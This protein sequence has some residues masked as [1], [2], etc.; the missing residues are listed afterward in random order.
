MVVSLIDMRK[1]NLRKWALTM[2]IVVA[3]AAIPLTVFASAPSLNAKAYIVVDADTG[4]ILFE[5]NSDDVLVPASMT[6]L[7]TL[8]LTLEK[9]NNNKIK[10]SDEAKISEYSNKISRVSS[11]S[12]YQLPTGSIYSIE[13]LYFGAAINSSN[14]SAIALSEYIAGDETGFIALMNDKARNFGLTDT[15][16]VN[17]S[18]LNNS[19]LYGFHPR[20]TGKNEDTKISARSMATVAYRLVNDYPEIINTS[21]LVQKTLK[22]GQPGEITIRSTNRLLPSRDYAFEGAKGL[23]TGYIYNAGYC[24]AGYAERPSGRVISVVMGAVSS[25]ERFRGSAKLM[26][27]GFELLSEKANAKVEAAYG[28]TA[29]GAGG[30]NGATDAGGMENANGA[31]VGS[32]GNG[33]NSS[34]IGS[35]GSGGNSSGSGSGGSGGSYDNGDSGV[36]SENASKFLY[37]D[38]LN[39]YVSNI[40]ISGQVRADAEG[41]AIFSYGDTG[42]GVMNNGKADMIMVNGLLY[43]VSRS[44]RVIELVDGRQV[45]KAVMTYINRDKVF[46]INNV[47]SYRELEDA[48]MSRIED[49]S[50]SYCFK[51]DG[52]FTP[53]RVSTLS[54]G[55]E[56]NNLGGQINGT[57]IGFYMPDGSDTG[58]GVLE[59]GLTLYY[60]SGDKKTGGRLSGIGVK[61]AVVVMDKMESVGSLG[62][63]TTIKISKDVIFEVRMEDP[64]AKEGSGNA[65]VY[66]GA[67]AE[68]D[69]TGEY[70]AEYPIAS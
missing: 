68:L 3:V 57:V 56:L 25:E 11:L 29:T 15:K 60:I 45:K 33:G 43:S 46:K 32:G 18:G 4:E 62:R 7:M 52:V 5:K 58:A 50:E 69:A 13:D 61:E 21:S 41:R 9:V 44:G 34:G 70:G 17:S 66:G 22:E 54:A 67:A 28:E 26:E 64:V 38:R 63:G 40:G 37:P 6:K 2:I 23:K 47:N 36:G 49:K 39:V 8:Y 65:I 55:I 12:S 20:G 14:A 48:L 19:D 10:W 16:F 51:L 53:A 42:L 35:G 1:E 59:R 30:A 24:F 27:Y 31:T